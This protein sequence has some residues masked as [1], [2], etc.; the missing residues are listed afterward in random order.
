M[1]AIADILKCYKSNDRF[2][3]APR[4]M[5]AKMPVAAETANTLV[6]TNISKNNNTSIQTNI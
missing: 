6:H 1:V 5:A 4:L 3:K 2:L